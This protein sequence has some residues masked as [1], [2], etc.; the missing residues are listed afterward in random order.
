VSPVRYGPEFYIPE[1]DTLHSQSR[2]ILKSYN[3]HYV[4]F[5]ILILHTSVSSG[6]GILICIFRLPI[7]AVSAIV[8][9]R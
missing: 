9:S 5:L 4:S 3:V 6:A 8:N 7:T 2:E 1:D